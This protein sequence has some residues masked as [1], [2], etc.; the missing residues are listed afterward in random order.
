MPRPW[1]QTPRVLTLGVVVLAG[2]LL[3]LHRFAIL[4][5]VET[6]GTKIFRPAAGVLAEGAHRFTALFATI[7]STRTLQQENLRLREEN[8]SLL[9]A[10]EQQRLDAAESEFV[11]EAQRV[12]GERT[13]QGTVTRVIGRS[14]DPTFHLYLVNRGTRAGI[15]PGAAVMVGNGLFVGK[16]LESDSETAKILLVTDSHATIAGL[17]ENTP[18]SQGIVTGELGL[19]LKIDLLLKKDSVEIGQTVVTSGIDEGIPPGLVIGRIAHVENPPGALFQSATVTP[20]ADLQRL[21]V[22]T[23]LKYHAS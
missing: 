23:V 1:F 11:R 8:Q 14:S 16:V 5:P 21:T 22:V 15:Q 10:A 19:S 6:L 18:R 17:V 9:L 3:L 20:A 2:I 12:L 13:W 7:G 4:R